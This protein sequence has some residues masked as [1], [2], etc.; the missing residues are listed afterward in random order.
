MV[1]RGQSPPSHPDQCALL[2]LLHLLDLLQHMC[3]YTHTCRHGRRAGR[4]QRLSRGAVHGNTGGRVGRVQHSTASSEGPM[5]S[6]TTAAA[7]TVTAAI[8][9]RNG[10]GRWQDPASTRGSCYRGLL[11]LL[12]LQERSASARGGQAPH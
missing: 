6:P 10:E 5:A 7:A 2:D 1:L 8:V 11:L 12:H 9:R 3:T 4:V